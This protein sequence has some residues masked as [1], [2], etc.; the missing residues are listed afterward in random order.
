MSQPTPTVF[1]IAVFREDQPGPQ[2]RVFT[3]VSGLVRFA[4]DCEF[5]KKRPDYPFDCG[6][7][8]V[9]V[10]NTEALECARYDVAPL[11]KLVTPPKRRRA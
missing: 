4:E 8:D 7:Y 5:N 6:P 9:Y 3:S 1:Y 11:Q 10:V 2:H